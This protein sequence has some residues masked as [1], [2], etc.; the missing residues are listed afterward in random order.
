MDH[1]N[2]KSRDSFRVGI[3]ITLHHSSQDNNA[4]EIDYETNLQGP[5]ASKDP[6]TTIS[7]W[8]LGRAGILDNRGCFNSPGTGRRVPTPRARSRTFLQGGRTECTCS[9]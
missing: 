2:A 8:G 1:S 3:V 5:V 7:I 6:G 4:S 9:S